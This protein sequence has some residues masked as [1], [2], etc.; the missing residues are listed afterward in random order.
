M[1]NRPITMLAA[2]IF[3][4]MALVHVYRLVTHFQLIV[5]SH[6]IPETASY[7]AIVVAGAL[8]IGLYREARR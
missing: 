5:G 3:A 2:I 8:A 6:V 1:G 7:A 4:V